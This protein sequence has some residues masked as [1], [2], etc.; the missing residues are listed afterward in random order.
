MEGVAA[1]LEK[2]FRDRWC[3][4]VSY[5]LGRK[6]HHGYE[7]PDDYADA[8]EWCGKER[9]ERQLKTFYQTHGYHHAD[10]HTPRKKL[11]G[12]KKYPIHSAAK[13]GN[14]FVV[15]QLLLQGPTRP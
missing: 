3:A 15:I 1:D 7:N 10:A 9:M 14:K 8:I 2:R 5:L 4:E 13:E 6:I 12:A 11:F